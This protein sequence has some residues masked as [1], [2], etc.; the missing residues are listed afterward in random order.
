MLAN[1]LC[2]G[3]SRSFAKNRRA[4]KMRSTVASHQRLTLTKWEQSSKLILF[5]LCKNLPWTQCQSYDGCLGF[6]ENWKDEKLNKWVSHELIKTKKIVLK[7]HLLLFH[8]TT[9]NHFYIRLLWHVTKRDFIWQLVMTSSV[10]GPIRS[11]KALPKAKFVL[12]EG[13]GQCLVVCCPSDPLQRSES[14]WNH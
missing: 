6:Q 12:K 1:V 13:H 3:G 2:S 5:Q 4:L 10:G 11:S 8:A 14:W 7:C 9:T